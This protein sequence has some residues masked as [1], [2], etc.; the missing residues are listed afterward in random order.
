MRPRGG[1][2]E[3]LP[4]LLMSEAALLISFL[5]LVAGVG[6]GVGGKGKMP[7]EAQ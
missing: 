6:G 4:I 7:T 2:G 1:M 3:W 5:W